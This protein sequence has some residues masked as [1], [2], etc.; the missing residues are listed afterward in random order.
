M[1]V[2][3]APPI[4]RDLLRL[5]NEFLEM[6]GLSVTVPQAG[7]LFGLRVEHAERILEL[8]AAEGFLVHDNT[9]AYR[10]CRWD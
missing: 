10:R 5:R 2:L 8:L 1:I 7:R 4:E 9:G 6:P 3:E